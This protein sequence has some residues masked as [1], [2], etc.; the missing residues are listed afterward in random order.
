M[1]FSALNRVPPVTDGQET[2]VRINSNNEPEPSDLQTFSLE[3]F[4]PLVI[5][6]WVTRAGGGG[7]SSLEALQRNSS[8]WGVGGDTHT[9]REE[10][11]GGQGAPFTRC[12]GY[13]CFHGNVAASEMKF[14]GLLQLLSLAGR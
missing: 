13:R 9:G 12:H 11:E 1:D 7:A 2:L 5:V 14:E 6:V 3:E 8:R 4:I 10:K